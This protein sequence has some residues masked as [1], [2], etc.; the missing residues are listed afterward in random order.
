ML[1]RLTAS[2][3]AINWPWRSHKLV[4]RD[5]LGNMYFEGPPMRAGTDRTRRI[6]E[7]FDGRTEYY[8]YEP[9]LIPAQW[10]AWLRHTRNAPPSIEEL[11][12]AEAQRLL[13][14]QRAREL[15]AKWEQRK[16]EIEQEKLASL[17]AGRPSPASPVPPPTAPSTAPVGQGETFEP[18]AWNPG[19]K[20]RGG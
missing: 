10:Q 19:A 13:T 14:I 16:I 9:E 17:P 7:Y 11:Q 20:W 18:G 8:K 3:K 1:G 5:L 6:I 4:G 12:Q 15:D 2:L